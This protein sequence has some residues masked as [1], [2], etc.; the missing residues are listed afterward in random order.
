M[1]DVGGTK[2]YRRETDMCA[3]CN[4]EGWEVTEEERP[5]I[6]EVIESAERTWDKLIEQVQ[7]DIKDL[8][9]EE[10]VVLV[11]AKIGYLLQTAQV[12]I[13][14]AIWMMAAQLVRQSER[15]KV[16]DLPPLVTTEQHG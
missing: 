1:K 6:A 12:E 4:G 14:S 11:Q 2:T 8:R 10:A 7:D 5:A 9:H 3:S 15:I 16:E 13:V